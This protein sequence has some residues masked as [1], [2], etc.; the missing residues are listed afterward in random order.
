MSQLRSPFFSLP[1]VSEL[2][3]LSL[4]RA[5]SPLAGDFEFVF[6]AQKRLRGR[7]KRKDSEREVEAAGTS[8][9]SVRVRS[10]SALEV[11]QAQSHPKFDPRPVSRFGPLFFLL[12]RGEGDA[13]RAPFSRSD[14]Q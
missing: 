7:S 2:F 13:K 10:W 9:A 4:S 6:E 14:R 11:N 8:T 5:L 12:S 3:S 1:L